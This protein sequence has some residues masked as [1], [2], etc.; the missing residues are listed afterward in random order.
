ERGSPLRLMKPNPGVRRIEPK[1]RVGCE[2]RDFEAMGHGAEKQI[3]GGA[4]DSMRPAAVE[5]MRRL[6]VVLRVDLQIPE[7]TETL[8]NCLEGLLFADPRQNLLANRADENRFPG[9]HQP[10][11]LQD[12]QLLVSF[13][14]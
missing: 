13:K 12:E 6:I 10:R 9:P 8:A 5:E 3:D 7:I 1:I 4:R 2:D 14:V 11:P